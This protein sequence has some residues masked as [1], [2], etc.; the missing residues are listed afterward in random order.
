MLF[1][2]SS[3]SWGNIKIN[4]NQF[5]NWYLDIQ[6]QSFRVFF[7]QNLFYSIWFKSNS[8]FSFV[9]LHSINCCR[10]TKQNRTEQNT[11][12]ALHN[13]LFTT[14]FRNIAYR[15]HQE[16]GFIFIFTFFPSLVRSFFSFVFTQSKCIFIQLII[17]IDNGPN[18]SPN[19]FSFFYYCCSAHWIV[20][21]CHKT[22]YRFPLAFWFFSV[23]GSWLRLSAR[24]FE[25][26][27]F[28][29]VFFLFALFAKG[30]HDGKISICM[31][32]SKRFDN[33]YV[34]VVI[35]TNR[36]RE[37]EREK[38]KKRKVK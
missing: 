6:I 21:M 35:A 23:F 33:N 4:G 18:N 24:N 3:S 8:L 5:R 27:T 7:F 19:C 28:S 13:R 1:C 10:K 22:K 34:C 9:L 15:D 12:S 2:I 25:C 17:H 36:C 32:V 38:E 26:V 31:K 14:F 20:E 29:R 16:I 11:K 37:K 30:R